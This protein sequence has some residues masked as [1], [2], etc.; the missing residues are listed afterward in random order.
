[1]TKIWNFMNGRV[2]DEFC[3]LAMTKIITNKKLKNE[4]KTRNFQVQFCKQSIIL[5]GK[6]TQFEMPL[7][8]NTCQEIMN[9]WCSCFNVSI[10]IHFNLLNYNTYLSFYWQLLLRVTFSLFRSRNNYFST[11]FIIEFYW[12]IKKFRISVIMLN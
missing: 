5:S 11:G 7:R 10:I 12:R 1:M 9:V 4:A 6:V 2:G 8:S 3:N